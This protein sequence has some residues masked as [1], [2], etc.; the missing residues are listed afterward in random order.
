MEVPAPGRTHVHR[1]RHHQLLAAR[2]D[3]ARHHDRLRPQRPDRVRRPRASASPREAGSTFECKLDAGASRGLHLAARPHRPGRTARTPS[4]CAPPTP[5]ATPTPRPATR[6]WTVDTAAPDTTIDPARPGSIAIDVGDLRLHRHRG[7]RD[8]RVQARR[9]RRGTT[10]TSPRTLTA[11]GDGAHTFR[12]RATRRRRQRPTPRPATRTLTVDTVAPDTTIDSGPTRADGLHHAELRASPPTTRPRRSSASSTSRRF[13]ACTSPRRLHRPRRRRAHLRGARDATPPATSTPRPADAHLDRRHRRARHHDHLRPD[14]PD[15][16]RRRHLRVLLERGRLDVRVQARRRGAWQPCTSPRALTRPRRRRAHLPVRATDA[17][18]NVD[19][20]PG[21]AHL[22]RRHHRARHDDRLAARRGA[23]ASA[24]ATLRLLAPTP[25]RHVRV[26]ARRRRASRP[27]P[28]RARYTGLADGR[29]T[30]AVRATDAAGNVDAT[31][32][33]RTWT[34]DTAA[35]DTT[36]DVGPAAARGHRRGAPSP[37]PPPSRARRFECKLDAGRAMARRAPRRARSPASPTAATRSACARPTPPATSTPARPRAPGRSTPRRPTRRSTP[38]RPGT[39]QPRARHRS[40]FSTEAGRDVRVQARRRAPGRPARRRGRSTGS[41]TA[42]TRFTR[43]RHRRRRQRRTPTPATRTWTVDTAAPETRRSRRARRARPPRERA[44]FAF[45]RP[46]PGSASSASSTTRP[47]DRP[48]TRPRHAHRR[49]P[50]APTR[51]GARD[52]RRRQPR[53]Q[54]RRRAPG[55]STRPRRTRRS[56]AARRA[57]SPPRPPSFTFTVERG[58]A[59]PSSAGWTPGPWEACSSP[60]T[61]TR[62]RRREPHVLGPG[63]R[64]GRQRRRQRGRARTWT[65]DTRRARDHDRLRP[66]RPDGDHVRHV[67]VHLNETGSTF[68]CK[69]DSGAL[70]GLHVAAAR[71]TGLAQG[72]HTLRV[73]ATD[74]AGN[75]DASEAARTW[76]ADTVEPDTTFDSAPE[77]TTAS[78]RAEFAFG[79]GRGRRRLRVPARRR[80]MAGLHVA[81]RPDRARERRPRLPRACARRGGEPRPDAG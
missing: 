79:S 48:A 38:A 15:Q 32:A 18:G 20:T 9:R 31:P 37:S 11:L 39:T 24:S 81:P 54:R 62:A 8:V 7:R 53:R 64:R 5:P 14:R 19:A 12:V 23:V 57:P 30:F 72:E 13:A 35:P 2:Q 58:R 10:C 67:R 40:R 50:T 34:V 60:R 49:W 27:A 56:P 69:L 47:G 46:R 44:T 61:L 80:G 33:T 75:V 16:Q 25:S 70:A 74:A 65:V 21:D 28:R 6:T 22:D 1:L 42:R 26:Q 68:E 76:I 55:R 59:R 45:T 52:G 29:H 36:I 66:D 51:S 63:D 71:Y 17:A 3:R 43:A 78:N 73:R 4:R 41:P 77:A